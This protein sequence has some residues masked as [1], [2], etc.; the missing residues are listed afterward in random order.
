MALHLRGVVLTCVIGMVRCHYSEG[1]LCLPVSFHQ[2]FPAG[3]LVA[4]VLP[5]RVV[6][7]RRFANG[8]VGGWG[9]VGLGGTDHFKSLTQR[10][11]RQ[12]QQRFDH[13]VVLIRHRRP[14]RRRLH[15]FQERH[16]LHQHLY[17]RPGCFERLCRV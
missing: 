9:L 12:D 8:Q 15:N 3:N 2:K 13:P 6:Q 11:H 1:K 17:Q 10:F 7:Q 4:R 14:H 16:G 5:H